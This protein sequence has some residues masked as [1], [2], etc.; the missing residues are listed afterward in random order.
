MKPQ[1]SLEIYKDLSCELAARVACALEH[2]EIKYWQALEVFDD[3]KKLFTLIV[4]DELATG[5]K[6]NE[7]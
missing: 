5:D 4:I 2:K 3:A 6:K 1:T 7:D